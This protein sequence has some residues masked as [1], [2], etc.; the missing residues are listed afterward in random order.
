MRRLMF[1]T[2]GVL[3]G[4]MLGAAVGLLLTPASGDTL[5]SDAKN[6]FADAKAEARLA[7]EQRRRELEAQLAA[8]TRTPAQIR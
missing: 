2:G 5:R 4:L 1:F 3:C 7:S 8:Y 6:R